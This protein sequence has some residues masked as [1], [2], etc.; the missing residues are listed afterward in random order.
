MV[1][2][3]TNLTLTDFINKVNIFKMAFLAYFKVM[4]VVTFMFDSDN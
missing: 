3:S 2:A 1:E 4:F